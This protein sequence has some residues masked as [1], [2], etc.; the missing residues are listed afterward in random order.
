MFIAHSLQENGP[1]PRRGGTL[2]DAAGCAAPPGLE[3]VIK[4]RGG[5]NHV[6]PLELGMARR[7]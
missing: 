6:A 7:A 4:G 5:Y 1:K 2:L 3:R